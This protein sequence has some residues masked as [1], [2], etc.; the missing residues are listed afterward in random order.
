MCIASN[1]QHGI[2]ALSLDCTQ[3]PHRYLSTRIPGWASELRR[4]QADTDGRASRCRTRPGSTAPTPA[5]SGRE[6]RP[7]RA[8]GSSARSWGAFV[9]VH[10]P[11]LDGEHV[12]NCQR[13]RHAH[14]GHS[15]PTVAIK[16]CAG[17]TRRLSRIGRIASAAIRNQLRSNRITTALVKPGSS[18]AAGA[19]SRLA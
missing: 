10:P 3:A 17:D 8:V 15:S 16:S 9:R 18:T 19:R 13:S 1:T 7:A 14:D 6:P 12:D 2:S 11:L 5:P 4:E